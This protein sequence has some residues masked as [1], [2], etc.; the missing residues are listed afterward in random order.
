MQKRNQIL[1][2]FSKQNPVKHPLF[3][4]LINVTEAG[5]ES[6]GLRFHE[7]HRDAARMARAA[8]GAYRISRFVAI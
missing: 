2:L 5:L 7:T 8:A 6:E 4:G 3:S 1:S